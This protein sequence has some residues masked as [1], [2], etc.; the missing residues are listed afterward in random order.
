MRK[1]SLFFV[2]MLALGTTQAQE[3]FTGMTGKKAMKQAARL[4]SSYN[5]DQ[6][7][8]GDKLVQAKAAIDHATKQDDIKEDPKLWSTMGEIYN[9][10]VGLDQTKAL[11]DPAYVAEH[12]TGGMVAFQAYKKV[13][14]MDPGNKGALSALVTTIGSITNSGLAHYEKQEYTEAFSSFHSVLD[15]HKILES[16]EAPSPFDVEAELDNQYYITGLA[17]MNGGDKETARIYFGKLYDKGY[18]KPAVYDAMYMLTVDEDMDKA[19]E[20]L[21]AAR[22][23][24]PEDTGLLFAEINHYLRQN[25]IEELEDKLVKAIEIEPENPSLYS[26][27]GN[28]YDKKY[29][30]AFKDGNIDEADQHFNSAVEFYE[31]GVEVKPDY[32][33]AIYSIGALYYNRAAFYTQEMNALAEDYSKAGTEKYEL[34]KAQVEKM[35]VEALPYLKRV[36][37]LDP[38]DR[39]TLIALKEIYARQND[40]DL[41]NVFKDR[42]EKVEAGETIEESYFKQ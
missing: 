34:K 6:T 14:E 24:Y 27:M 28:I 38:G 31:K 29:Q 16:N 30:T 12:S 22:E 21:N 42:L 36:E 35:F 17:A 20:I 19:E 23:K 9:G 1:I 7:K 5:L 15:I 41:S 37:A 39:N 40:F 13:L 18:D 3:D 25:R 26:T 4:L 2:L 33:D 32:S 8:N 11:L 10:L